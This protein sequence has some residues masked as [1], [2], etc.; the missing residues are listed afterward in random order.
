[1]IFFLAKIFEDHLKYLHWSICIEAFMMFNVL[2]SCLTATVS[3]TMAVMFSNAALLLTLTLHTWGT[4]VGPGTLQVKKSCAREGTWKEGPTIL[5]SQATQMSWPWHF[6]CDWVCQGSS[7]LFPRKL[8]EANLFT[9][10]YTFPPFI[11]IWQPWGPCLSFLFF[12]FLRW[13]FLLKVGKQIALIFGVTWRLW[14]R[15]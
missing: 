7:I 4:S 14:M 11:P 1:M 2:A 9:N 13:H 10:I 8:G 6:I 15:P 3:A 12:L 5:S